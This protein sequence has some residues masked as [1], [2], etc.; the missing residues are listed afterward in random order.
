MEIDMLSGQ[1][2]WWVSSPIQD[3][4]R[5][6]RDVVA[7]LNVQ[8]P[9]CSQGKWKQGNTAQRNKTILVK[10]TLVQQR[11]MSYMTENSK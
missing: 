5:K 1:A 8:M 9:T 4:P 2:N 11:Y 6:L 3:Q 10:S 7:F